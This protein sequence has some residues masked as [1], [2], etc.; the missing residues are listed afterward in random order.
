MATYPLLTRRAQEIAARGDLA[1]LLPSLLRGAA[2]AVVRISVSVG[3]R[4]DL[5]VYHEA[6]AARRPFVLKV[7]EPE[8][9]QQ[10]LAPSQPG[11][12]LADQQA[13]RTRREQANGHSGRAFIA[14]DA[15]TGLPCFVQWVFSSADNREI[16][17]IFDGRFPELQGGEVLFENAF[18][19]PQFRG[20][21]VMPAAMS[22]IAARVGA[23]GYHTGL[24]FVAEGNTPSIN[25]CTKAGFVPFLVRRDVSVLRGLV[26][27]R[28]FL[29]HK[30]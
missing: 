17:R 11:L 18:T 21:G 29:P 12:S 30:H 7:A 15:A 9:L 26:R 1:N 25:G 20:F 4:R 27:R 5:T 23:E 6:P 22:Q 28:Q 19:P 14:L 8:Q 3:L 10:I 24:T 13:L 2:R 16:A